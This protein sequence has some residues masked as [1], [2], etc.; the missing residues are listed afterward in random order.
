MDY[1]RLD[2]LSDLLKATLKAMPSTVAQGNRTRLEE[3][4]E[5]IQNSSQEIS[6]VLLAAQRPLPNE[7]YPKFTS[8][9]SAIFDIVPTYHK[10][11]LVD[12]EL[13]EDGA[14]V[15][16]PGEELEEF[17]KWFNRRIEEILNANKSFD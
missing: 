10:G 11:S 14:S 13:L 3:L 15:G 12:V 16:L 7:P 1:E 2:V 17:Q 8:L 6:Q 4:A 9:D 5:A